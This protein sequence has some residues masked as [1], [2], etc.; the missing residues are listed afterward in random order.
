MCGISGKLHFDRQR[1]VVAG[2]IRRMN[3]ALAHRGPDGEGVFLKGSV[4]LGHRR[5]AIIDLSAEARQPMANEDGSVVV[6]VNGEIYNF[7]ELRRELE[8][9]GHRFRSRS[10]S[11]VVVHLYEEV[12]PDCVRRLRGMFAFALWDARRRVLLLAR[13]AAGEK[14]LYY[15]LDGEGI[16]FASELWALL[17]DPS[18][19]ADPDPEALGQYLRFGYVPSPW[20]AFRGVRKLPAAHY[21]VVEDG[22]ARVERYWR[23]DYSRKVGRGASEAELCERLLAE[24]RAAV[25][26]Q[27][28][29]DVPIGAFL[30]GGV[31]SSTI[32]ALMTQV[33]SS[34]VKTFSI[35]FGEEDVNEAGFSRLVAARLGTSHHEQVVR[36]A[37]VDV[38]PELVRHYGEPFADPAAVPTYYLA[39][40]TREHVTVALSGD[41]GDENFAGY[42]HYPKLLRYP[43]AGRLPRVASR[44]LTSLTAPLRRTPPSLAA[45]V[46]RIVTV[47]VE[48]PATRYARSLELSGDWVTWLCRPEFAAR[49]RD[50]ASSHVDEGGI[51]ALDAMLKRDVE[52]GLPDRMLTKVD[53][54]AMANS[55]E[56][57]APMMDPGVMQL[58]ASL[59]PE[60][61]LR[62]VTGKYL[63]RRAVKGLI[64]DEVIS[65]RKQGFVVPVGRWLRVELRQ[66]ASDLLLSPG[67]GQRG[68]LDPGRVQRLVVDHMSGRVDRGWMI[69]RLLVLELWHQM[70]VNQRQRSLG[71]EAP[72]V[73]FAGTRE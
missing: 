70:V 71:R 39:R 62:G 51:G 50:D 12:G 28:V 3:R 46:G 25:Q 32:V 55:L 27:L 53:V 30:S 40:M 34:R 17:Q 13:D 68:Y 66:M 2:T 49:V 65:R 38:L 48:P 73:G 58:A 52:R 10:D 18:V 21:L 29:S 5:L 61:K 41:G 42:D 36:P 59:P 63:L 11:E 24:L 64:P 22:R 19:P 56:V 47:G 37:A 6:S 67:L 43:S 69:W 8:S 20:T 57:R 7:K 60:L 33:A 23:L 72:A 54:A 4:G 31:D 1:P 35:A 45:R 44:M 9:A 14:P 26:R 15:C 16:V